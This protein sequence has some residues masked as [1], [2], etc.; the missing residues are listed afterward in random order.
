[1]N[2]WYMHLCTSKTFLTPLSK[3]SLVLR[4]AS[5]SDLEKLLSKF[6][7]ASES[8]SGEQTALP[9]RLDSSFSCSFSGC[10]GK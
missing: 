3:F 9:H 1:M 2:H 8:S 10:P 5:Q 4:E 7:N 6:V